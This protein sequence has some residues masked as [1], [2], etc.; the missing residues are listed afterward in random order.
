MITSGGQAMAYVGAGVAERQPKQTAA[1]IDKAAR[2]KIL[3][4]V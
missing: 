4:T 3:F 1:M 2:C